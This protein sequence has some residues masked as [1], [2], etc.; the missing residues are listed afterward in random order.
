VIE[1]DLVIGADDDLAR[2]RNRLDR[3]QQH[4]GVDALRAQRR[5][6]AIGQR[7]AA[8]E[9]E[10][11]ILAALEFQPLL[12]DGRVGRGARMLDGPEHQPP[13]GAIAGREIG[14]SPTPGE[15]LDPADDL[16]VRQRFHGR[17]ILPCAA[18]PRHGPDP[19]ARYKVRGASRQA[20]NP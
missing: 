20:V 15:G 17:S 11:P 1:R 10:L 18:G 12:Q 7:D 3:G 16:V 8:G 9:A 4:R 2:G 13:R 14:L 19:S 5:D 6:R